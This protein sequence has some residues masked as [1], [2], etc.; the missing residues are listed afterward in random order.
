MAGV[1]A[2]T[3]ISPILLA[4]EASRCSNWPSRH[5]LFGVCLAKM[6]E[7]LRLT[8]ISRRAALTT[9]VHGSLVETC[10]DQSKVPNPTKTGKVVWRQPPYHG[11][12]F[13]VPSSRRVLLFPT[14]VQF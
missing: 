8:M 2:P 1:L 6:A 3:K 7:Q 9:L 5:V 14:H 4:S 11:V 10:S 12:A 13:N